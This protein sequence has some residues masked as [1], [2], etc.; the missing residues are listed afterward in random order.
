[1]FLILDGSLNTEG[2]L[3]TPFKTFVQTLKGK[4]PAGKGGESPFKLLTDG[5]FLNAFN[6]AND[7]FRAIEDAIAQTGVVGRPPTSTAS[8]KGT[9]SALNTRSGENKD[10]ETTSTEY[11]K[12]PFKLGISCDADS[13]FNKDPKDPNKYEIG[14]FEEGILVSKNLDFLE[15]SDEYIEFDK[16]LFSLS[17]NAFIGTD[18]LEEFISEY[19][20]VLNDIDGYIKSFD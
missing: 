14:D 13:F 6:N 5:S 19:F 12:S 2:S 17:F 1:M 4:F 9:D 11:L 15:N 8:K 20:E 18:M 10:E 7:A 3:L 16:K